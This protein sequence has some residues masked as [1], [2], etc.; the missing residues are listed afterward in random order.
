[1]KEVNIMAYIKNVYTNPIRRPNDGLLI[2][3]VNL[4]N[5]SNI[6]ILLPGIRWHSDLNKAFDILFNEI[7]HEDMDQYFLFYVNMHDALTNTLDKIH[8]YS[9]NGNS[10]MYHGIIDY[11]NNMRK[12]LEDGYV[13]NTL[14]YYNNHEIIKTDVKCNEIF[15]NMFIPA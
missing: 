9:S 14:A 15:V 1:M 4:N 2:G 11:C 5:I 8:E 3:C 13:L 10:S 6:R 7:L 12:T